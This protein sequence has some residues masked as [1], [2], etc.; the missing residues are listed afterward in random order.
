M[1]SPSALDRFPPARVPDRIRLLAVDDTSRA[2]IAGEDYPAD[3][4][5]GYLNRCRR[6]ADEVGVAL[7]MRWNHHAALVAAVYSLLPY[8]ESRWEDMD[9]SAASTGSSCDRELAEL[10]HHAVDEAQALLQQLGIRGD[11]P[12]AAERLAI[13][14]RQEQEPKPSATP[15][16]DTPAALLLHALVTL[17]EVLN[18]W[19]P[20]ELNL[21]WVP[22]ALDV[23]APDSADV[24]CDEFRALAPDYFP[25]DVC[26]LEGPRLPPAPVHYLDR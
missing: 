17:K 3:G 25:A 20:R 15:A 4:C 9:E 12:L 19:P 7:L 8:A 1:S 5:V 21:S 24:D 2:I 23:A 26:R 22:A 13:L 6:L 11:D 16:T 14:E 10:A 18:G